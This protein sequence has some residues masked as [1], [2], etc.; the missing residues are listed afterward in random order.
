MRVLIVGSRGQL[1]VDLVKSFRDCQVTP[2]TSEDLDITDEASVQQQIAFAAPDLVLNAAAFT[3]VDECE[4]EHIRAFS[5][6][7][8]GPRNLALAC[9]KWDA[10]L[11]HVSTNY[12]FDGFKGAPYDENDAARPLNAYGI[13][14]LAGE[15]YLQSLWEKVY[16]VRV[17]GLFGL[18][19]SRMKGTNFVEAMLRLGS[20][21]NPLR[22][23]SDEA[24]SPTYTVD[25]ASVI[26]RLVETSQYGIYHVTNSGGCTWLEFAR[27]IFDQAGMKVELQPVT[28][29]EYGAPARRP[30]DSRLA[31]RKTA[32]LGLGPLRPWQEALRDYLLQRRG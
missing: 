5:V 15:H 22:I 26:R 13:S 3:R 19:P 28:A 31:N 10:P 6:N 16:I 32:E 23:V 18:T 25:A 4:R 30:P 12:V 27:E 17:S 1:G 20:K 2:Y 11:L 8:I 14:K 21:G 24:L 7:A 9:K 29:S